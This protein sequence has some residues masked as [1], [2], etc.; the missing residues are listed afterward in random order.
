MAQNAQKLTLPEAVQTS[1]YDALVAL[2][3]RLAAVADECASARDLPPL[4]NR[5]Q[6]VLAEL[7][8]LDKE[9]AAQEDTASRWVGD[10]TF[11]P[12]TI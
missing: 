6:S 8:K 11:D 12:S 5:L 10:D 1:H 3:D 4:A 2:R 9:R 7:A